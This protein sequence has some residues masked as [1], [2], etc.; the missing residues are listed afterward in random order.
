MVELIPYSF[1]LM[2]HSNVASNLIQLMFITSAQG[3][4]IS[5]K[6]SRLNQEKQSFLLRGPSWKETS[7]LNKE[8]NKLFK[9]EVLYMEVESMRL[10]IHLFLQGKWVKD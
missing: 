5:D 3:I 9:V 4:M 7:Y 10:S 8:S 6:I 2:N 1:L